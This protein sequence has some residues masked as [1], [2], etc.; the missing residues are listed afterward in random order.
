MD[1]NSETCIHMNALVQFAHLP[2]FNQIKVLRL[3]HYC[4]MSG[5]IVYLLPWDK[6]TNSCQLMMYVCMYV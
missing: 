3:N 5:S 1:P 4:S 6:I 2:W